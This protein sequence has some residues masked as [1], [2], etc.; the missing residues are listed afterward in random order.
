MH[1]YKYSISLRI[2]HPNNDLSYFGPL[3][4]LESLREWIAGEPRKTPK[5]TS[6]DG[7]NKESYWCARLPNDPEYSETC[8]LEEKLIE[9]TSKLK[10]NQAEFDKLISEGGKI[11]YFVWIYCE[12]N[13]GFELNHR[14]L[15]DI[16]NLGI[17]LGVVCDP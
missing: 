10:A 12:K 2:R 8:S 11:D 6:L 1:P 17:T 7:V 4:K 14:L 15:R 13:L 3:L 5:N 16:S 9:W